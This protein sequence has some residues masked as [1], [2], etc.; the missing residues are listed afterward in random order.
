MQ[1]S[2]RYCPTCGVKA[3]QE[4]QAFEV[5]QATPFDRG[6]SRPAR[7]QDRAPNKVRPGKREI[8][9]NF[10]R[11]SIWALVGFFAVTAVEP[12]A[13][14]SGAIKLFGNPGNE[15]SAYVYTNLAVARGLVQVVYWAVVLRLI[16]KRVPFCSTSTLEGN[17]VER[18][19]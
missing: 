14:T 10:V 13:I 19:A 1:S 18:T 15:L 8:D 9:A 12:I 4:G 5:S 6:P 17:A 11:A 3:P 2:S 16:A 7:T